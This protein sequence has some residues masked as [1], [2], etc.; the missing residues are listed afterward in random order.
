MKIN[1][2]RLL[3]DEEEAR[4]CGVYLKEHISQEELGRRFNL[5]KRLVENLLRRQ[6]NKS[7]SHSEAVRGKYNPRWHGGI[8]FCGQYIHRHRP[9][10]PYAN[11]HGGV[12][13]HRLRMEE[14]IGRYL[15]PSEVVHHVDGKP[16][17][18]DIRNLVLLSGQSEHA[19]LHHQKQIT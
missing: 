9:H 8:G 11:R 7:R 5:G 19:R 17:N 6:G 10:H 16:Y 12:A 2:D 14:H 18:N 15:L 1:E 13:E 3:S 4:F